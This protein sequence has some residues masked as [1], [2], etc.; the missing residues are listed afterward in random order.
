M[1]TSGF[2][3]LWGQSAEA[4]SETV[5]AHGTAGSIGTSCPHCS[6]EYGICN[7]T[8][9]WYICTCVLLKE[10]TMDER[11]WHEQVW[12]KTKT[13][14]VYWY[15][16][17][18]TCKKKKKNSF[19][20]VTLWSHNTLYQ[21]LWLEMHKIFTY[22]S[23]TD[24]V[25]KI[26][27]LKK[28]THISHLCISHSRALCAQLSWRYG[29][30]RNKKASIKRSNCSL[31]SFVWMLRSNERADSLNRCGS[32]CSNASS[33]AHSSSSPL[34]PVTRKSCN[35]C[36]YRKAHFSEEYRRPTSVKNQLVL[37]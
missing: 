12:F 26:V 14:S 5:P 2:Y 33:R 27:W 18:H 4:F 1:P 34:T 7:N 25:F 36:E 20:Q 15:K 19:Q 10:C 3:W 30:S 16:Q 8:K 37:Q 22:I 24:T 29:E 31:T 35:K 21:L 13:M 23:H 28:W 9:K 6:G 11:Y 17:M 32:N